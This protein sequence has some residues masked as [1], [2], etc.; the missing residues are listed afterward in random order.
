VAAAVDVPWTA[1]TS[2]ALTARRSVNRYMFLGLFLFPTILLSNA[3]ICCTV[4]SVME[5]GR[6][7]VGY[8]CDALKLVALN[9]VR[10]LA[11]V[12]PI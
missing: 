3:Y 4:C 10:V 9:S 1:S 11:Y 6:A 7:S 2:A 5:C 12:A 8:L